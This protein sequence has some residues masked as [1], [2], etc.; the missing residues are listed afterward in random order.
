MS[1]KQIKHVMSYMSSLNEDVLD[2]N[3]NINLNIDDSR[4]NKFSSH[5]EEQQNINTFNTIYE[6][7]KDIVNSRNT[8]YLKNIS[9]E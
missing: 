3:N 7:A 1:Q 2:N 4:D 6:I 9:L 8:F 5:T